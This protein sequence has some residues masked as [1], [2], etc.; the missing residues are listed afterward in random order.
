MDRRGTGTPQSFSAGSQPA[1]IVDS[2]CQCSCK[3]LDLKPSY[4]RRTAPQYG[5]G[6]TIR[7]LSCGHR[8]HDAPSERTPTSLIHHQTDETIAKRKHRW[9]P[10]LICCGHRDVRK[11]APNPIDR[12]LC[13]RD[14]HHREVNDH[15]AVATNGDDIQPN[16]RFTSAT[17]LK[18][19]HCVSPRAP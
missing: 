7:S 12:G 18:Y 17:A 13:R 10:E 15:D 1:T 4:D 16:H 6:A 14:V 3:R 19:T 9:P 5:S 11:E 2:A 8:T